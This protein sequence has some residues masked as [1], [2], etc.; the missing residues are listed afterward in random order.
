VDIGGDSATAISPDSIDVLVVAGPTERLDDAA[1]AR[2]D[3][4]IEEGGSA[5][6]LLEPI[7]LDPQSPMPVPVQSGLETLL[8]GWGIGI[9]TGMVADLASSEQVSLG[10]RGLFNMIAPYPLWPVAFAGAEHAVTKGLSSMSFAWAMALEVQDTAGVTP[11]W[12]TSEAGAVVGLEMPILPDQDWARVVQDP[13]VKVL[14]AAVTPA[15]DEALGRVIVVGDASFAEGQFVQSNPGNLSFLANSIDW[16]A[17]D[18]AL[19]QIRSKD[20]TPPALAFASDLK[21]NMLKW[22]NL[23][24]LPLLFVV[25]GALRVTGRRRRAEARWKEVVP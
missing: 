11:L 13:G 3:G 10:R 8:D 4:F 7:R 6:L 14:A 21:K 25:G 22:G 2:V 24:G 17:R 5:L 1:L 23:V 12:E 19:I 9:S 18:E 15:D 20:R 16:L